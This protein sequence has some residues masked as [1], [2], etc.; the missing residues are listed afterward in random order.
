M[1]FQ[2]FVYYVIVWRYN[3]LI[4][5]SSVIYWKYARAFV[6][7]NFK[8]HLCPSLKKITGALKDI[9]DADYEWRVFLERTLVEAYVDNKQIDEAN[10]LATNLIKFIQSYLAPSFFDEF[11]EFLVK[12]SIKILII[13]LNNRVFLFWLF[14]CCI[15]QFRWKTICSPMK[16]LS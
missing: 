6:K 15:T 7:P 9:D 12:I 2:W 10:T 5:N 16:I 8:R 1:L 11:F 3:F 13:P 4:Y 14:D